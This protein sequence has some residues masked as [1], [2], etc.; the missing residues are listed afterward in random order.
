MTDKYPTTSNTILYFGKL[1]QASKVL[2]YSTTHIK[3]KSITKVEEENKI[4]EEFNS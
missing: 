2:Q 3:Y 4:Y 1:L